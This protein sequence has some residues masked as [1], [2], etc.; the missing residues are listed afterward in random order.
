MDEP[1]I[2]ADTPAREPR[3]GD[4]LDEADTEEEAPP[5]YRSFALHNPG[6]HAAL[7]TAPRG[8]PSPNAGLVAHAATQTPQAQAASNVAL[9]AQTGSTPD[10]VAHDPAEN[11]R[12]LQMAP[13]RVLYG[14]DTP[15]SRYAAQGPQQAAVLQHEAPQYDFLTRWL[16]G[17]PGE[18]LGGTFATPDAYDVPEI[19]S[20]VNSA[21]GKGLKTLV[22][23][24][25]QFRAFTLKSGGQLGMAANL[26][27]SLTDPNDPLIGAQLDALG[28]GKPGSA[29][30]DFM[31]GGKVSPDM[32]EAAQSHADQLTKEAN[33]ADTE[34]EK[35]SSPTGR[36]VL[37]AAVGILPYVAAGPLDL[38]LAFVQG[39]GTL[40]AQGVAPERAAVGGAVSTLLMHGLTQGLRSSLTPMLD[41]KLGQVT[42]KNFVRDLFS[43]GSKWARLQPGA[44]MLASTAW[45]G[46]TGWAT[47]AGMDFTS[48]LTRLMDSAARAGKALDPSE[49]WTEARHAAANAR[50]ILPIVASSSMAGHLGQFM[51]AHAAAADH[52]VYTG[53]VQDT[54][55]PSVAAQE[56]IGDTGPVTPDGK[57]PADEAAKP[58]QVEGQVGGPVAGG[59]PPLP[60]GKPKSVFIDPARLGEVMQ[61]AGTPVSDIGHFLEENGVSKGAWD[62]A[63]LS[64]QKVEMPQANYLTGM[65]QFHD[66]LRDAVTRDPDGHV[67]ATRDGD[68]LKGRYA[69]ELYGALPDDGRGTVPLA[70]KLNPEQIA[71]LE[72]TR[73]N[74]DQ[75]VGDGD[76]LHG[77]SSDALRVDGKILSREAAN[78]ASPG[79]PR[80]DLTSAE[81]AQVDFEEAHRTEIEY[82][83]AAHAWQ[84]SLGLGPSS[85]FFDTSHMS[86]EERLKHT[87]THGPSATA[88]NKVSKEFAETLPLEALK[89]RQGR[90]ARAASEAARDIDRLNK[91]SINLLAGAEQAAQAGIAEAH[92]GTETGQAGIMASQFGH[93]ISLRNLRK[94]VREKLSAISFE[95]EMKGAYVA[96]PEVLGAVR[97]AVKSAVEVAVKQGVGPELVAEA[98]RVAVRQSK[99]SYYSAGRKNVKAEDFSVQATEGAVDAGDAQLKVQELKGQRDMGQALSKAMARTY[100]EASDHAQTLKSAASS[101]VRSDL[102]GVDGETVGTSKAYGQAHDLLMESL[103]LRTPDGTRRPASFA[104]G[105]SFM[106]N[107]GFEPGFD[108]AALDTLRNNPKPVESMTV[109]ELRNVRE[110]SD[111][112]R[113]GAK[114][115]ASTVIDTEVLNRKAKINELAQTLPKYK[116]PEPSGLLGRAVAAL[117]KKTDAARRNIQSYDFHTLLHP[118]GDVG[119]SFDAR[120]IRARASEDMLLNEHV[121]P[122]FGPEMQGALAKRGAEPVDFPEWLPQ[123]HRDL[124]QSWTRGDA[125]HLG[126]AA[127]TEEGL[128]A[129]SRSFGVEGTEIDGWLHDTLNTKE[130]WDWLSNLYKSSEKFGDLSEAVSSNH[131][132]TPMRRKT[133]R[134]ITT[135]WGNVQGGY[136]SPIYWRRDAV[137]V[138]PNRASVDPTAGINQMRHDFT[139]DASENSQGIVDIGWRR[140][141]SHYTAEARYISKY[142]L[143]SDMRRMFQDPDFRRAVTDN[144]G[145]DHM[146]GL[147]NWY[148]VVAS[149]FAQNNVPLWM[150]DGF[151]A[152][153][154]GYAVRS[155][156]LSNP[157]VLAVQYSHPLIVKAAEGANFDISEG[158][159]GALSPDARAY[160][161]QNSDVV[162][163]RATRTV[164]KMYKAAAQIV[165]AEGPGKIESALSAPLMQLQHYTDLHLCYQLFWGSKLAAQRRGMTEPEADS[166]ADKQTD[167]Y[168][169]AIDVQGKS[170]RGT[171]PVV[172][173]LMLAKNFQAT[174]FNVKARRMFD[175][176]SGDLTSNGLLGSVIE[177]PLLWK[178]GLA[179]AIGIPHALIG[180]HLRNKEEQKNG[181][182]GVA[183]M[184]GRILLDGATFGNYFTNQ[185]AHAL[186]PAIFG[187]GFPKD[188]HGILETPQGQEMAAYLRDMGKIAKLAQ[189][190]GTVTDALRAGLD[191]GGRYFGLPPPAI[192]R[193]VDG[194]QKSTRYLLLGQDRFDGVTPQTPIGFAG[195]AFWGDTDKYESN[196]AS[197][198]ENLWR[199]R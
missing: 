31:M 71:A 90:D 169:P 168:M 140:M 114:D 103:G 176:R 183:Q 89:A 82:E 28:I 165:D 54:K 163:Y 24:F 102:Y 62:A 2:D 155:A 22:A 70:G 36:G 137:L 177:S 75:T 132:G 170:F 119:A 9:A 175:A 84:S 3:P 74:N 135:P 117:D 111:Q 51:G 167:K 83:R 101:K 198:F 174:M 124:Y 161:M 158:I 34:L 182:W 35:Q 156:L 178:L 179:A 108:V 160:M 37:G 127:G 7:D 166:Y 4:S 133:P 17:V 39:T 46:V 172:G 126:A 80:E 8:V 40:N 199:G 96:T 189:G 181:G 148:T 130:D 68:W 32:V 131:A 16:T 60:I 19:P 66:Q 92:L 188:A 154:K 94:A 43:E 192:L 49:V 86:L 104:E 61:K 47:A 14:G 30:G 113:K 197:E 64:G 73:G 93:D 57:D 45:H 41:T 48:R 116:A 78:A 105:V 194:V 67:L 195:K 139:R 193:S 69:E 88:R 15:V 187:E 143:T 107:R 27:R 128:R 55:V 20:N 184:G 121:Y 59:E 162:R 56:I 147:D 190:K 109:G 72:G 159:A 125:L 91:K 76:R 33:P 85:L 95:Q 98:V 115:D 25:A 150:R 29:L 123:R 97:T 1:I 122:S 5:K 44:E 149:G 106:M 23:D 157:R 42:I 196:A 153:M 120:Y 186:G 65:S 13:L 77:T 191:A 81:Q 138:D 112:L 144:L 10:A 145:E 142:D 12:Q 53:A 152:K 171:D 146:R 50:Y 79:L 151:L 87:E 6:N 110:A 99:S 52:D 118:L 136:G 185:A 173:V 63:R 58:G 180:G 141:L 21:L 11:A 129:L 164:D 18:N 100:K 26:L 134:T 38:P